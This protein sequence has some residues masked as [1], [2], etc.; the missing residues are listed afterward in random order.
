[1]HGV[2]SG[3]PFH[4]SDH[5]SKSPSSLPHTRLLCE[6]G[7]CCVSLRICLQTRVTSNSFESA[8]YLRSPSRNIHQYLSLQARLSYVKTYSKICRRSSDGKRLSGDFSMAMVSSCLVVRTWEDGRNTATT[9]RKYNE[10]LRKSQ[11]MTYITKRIGHGGISTC[12]WA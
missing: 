6:N 12:W 2:L 5:G 8:R 1:M 11:E 4:H 10:G 7:R 3:R 9:T